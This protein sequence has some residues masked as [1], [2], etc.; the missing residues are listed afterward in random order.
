MIVPPFREVQ[1]RL[2]EYFREKGALGVV[3]VDLSQ[4]ARIERGFGVTAFQTLRSHL[5]SLLGEIGLAGGDL[6]GLTGALGK[7]APQPGDA[8]AEIAAPAPAQLTNGQSSV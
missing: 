5:D 1:P 3:L 6:R 7:P 2:A 8:A 4:L